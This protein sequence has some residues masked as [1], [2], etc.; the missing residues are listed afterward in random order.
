M[1]LDSPVSRR[2]LIRALVLVSLSFL[3][4]LSLT[5][6]AKTSL[7]YARVPYPEGILMLGGG[8]ERE[9]FT[10]R[11]AIDYPTLPVW[12]STGSRLGAEIFARYEIAAD[13]VTFDNR[14]TDTVTNFTTM[15][16]PLQQN[17]IRH[18]FLVTSDFHMP[19]ARAIASIVLGFH[20]INT[21]PVSVPTNQMDEPKSVVLRDMIRSCLW[22]L[23]GWSGAV[24]G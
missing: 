9:E 23:T 10:A 24:S 22:L 1:F 16:G 21:T 2:S 20:G 18:V 11:L 12:V 8:S 15:L 17:Q 19:R 7:T 13:R 3:G 6:L 14:A 5:I 4:V